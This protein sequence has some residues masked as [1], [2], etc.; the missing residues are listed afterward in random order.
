MKAVLFRVAFLAAAAASVGAQTTDSSS[1]ST[2][3]TTACEAQNIL[4][5]CLFT[6]ESYVSLCESTDYMCLCDKY[7][8]IMTCFNNCPN[9][10]REA[11]YQQQKDL[12]CMNASLYATTSGNRTV[13]RSITSTSSSETTTTSE[14]GGVK[15]ADVTATASSP[16]A[17]GL[18]QSGN[19]AG[20]RVVH[21]GG[22][23]AVLAGVVAYF[24]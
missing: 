10:S 12:Y 22:R 24:M 20:E 6:T 14:G 9:D 15:T 1:S 4:D 13:S 8:A 7:I 3:T 16:A 11:S 19:S 18:I 21:A 5:T 2:T 17:T 23:L